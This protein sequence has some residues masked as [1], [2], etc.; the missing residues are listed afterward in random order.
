MEELALWLSVVMNGI[1]AAVYLGILVVMLRQQRVM[2]QQRRTMA[3]QLEE[4]QSARV[5]AHRPLLVVQRLA[6]EPPFPVLLRAREA[7]FAQWQNIGARPALNVQVI[8]HEGNETLYEIR[9]SPVA[10]HGLSEPF[11]LYFHLDVTVVYND[12]FGNIYWT[13]YS[14]GR[15]T[16]RL[17]A[18]KPPV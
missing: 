17:G 12:L 14:P 4:M 3:Q 7:E 11:E 15:H 6:E 10:V 2:V 8:Y 9:L 5:A 18:G 13:H 16:Y 1:V